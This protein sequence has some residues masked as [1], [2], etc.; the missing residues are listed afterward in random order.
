[1]AA[2]EN[3]QKILAN[4]KQEL[5]A[6]QKKDEEQIKRLMSEYPNDWLYHY[7]ELMAKEEKQGSK[8]PGSA[9]KIL[10]REGKQKQ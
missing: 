1:M 9:S 2:N 5:A 8:K 10:F 4:L 6:K 7:H 3:E